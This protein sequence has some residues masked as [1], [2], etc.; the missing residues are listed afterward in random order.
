LK[1][2]CRYSERDKTAFLDVVEELLP[3]TEEKWEKVASCFNTQWTKH[4]CHPTRTAKGLKT[5]FQK[6]IYVSLIG[7]GKRSLLKQK[8]LH[9]EKFIDKKHS[10]IT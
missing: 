7:R 5:K 2:V 3:S 6:L 1:G 4:F 9:C 10:V 8:V